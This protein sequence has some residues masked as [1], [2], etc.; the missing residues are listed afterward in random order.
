MD[1]SRNMILAIV[2]SALVLIGWSFVSEQVAPTPP[3]PAPETAEEADVVLPASETA[4]VEETAVTQTVDEALG[5]ATAARIAIETPRLQGSINL[6]G[7]RIDDLVLLDHFETNEPD[8]APIRLLAPEGTEA[9]YFAHFGWAGDGV[10]MPDGDTI[11]QADSETLAPDSPVTMRW[12]NGTGQLFEIEL[13][14][15]ED[16]LFTVGQRVSNTSDAPISA[17][18]YA[19]LMHR[20]EMQSAGAPDP[21]TWLI[22]T[23]PYGFWDD[24]LH[25]DLDFSDL[26]EAGSAGERFALQNGWLGFNGKYWLGALAPAGDRQV[27]AA[28]MALT[29]GR[30]QAVFTGQ[31]TVI[32]AGRAMTADTHFFAG[33][34]ETH[35]LERYEVEAGIN[36]LDRAIDWGWFY[37]FELPLFYLLSWLFTTVGNFGVAIILMTFIVRGLMFPIAQKQ[38]SS[39]AGM[40]AVQPKMKELQERYKDD[41]PKMQQEVLALYQREKVNPLAGCLPIFLQIPIFYALYKVLLVSVEMRHEPFALWLQ[42]L[43]AP[44]PLT[45]VNLFGLL[46]FDPPSWLAIGILPI[47]LGI[48]MYLQFKLNPAQMDPT[49]QKI[50]EFMPWIFM[51]IMAPFAAGL[52]LYWVT[53][54]L[55]T[56]AQ[57]K[58]LYS[59]D[60][61]LKEQAKMAKE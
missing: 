51:F 49:Q 16:F 27:D 52:Q 28:F 43:S 36:Q 45:P 55:L 17:R 53:S 34:K 61:R 8:S 20:G 15:D 60:P 46:A 50:F 40:R 24:V 59:R 48:T 5:T 58:W 3:P 13:Q 2:L 11:W 23:G 38:F 35:L 42:D 47:L 1:S 7:A 10:E 6:R 37:W 4:P 18:P 29:D 26:D 21:D 39:M 33:A 41:K 14:V 32:E 44:D 25:R 19:L 22:H 31:P 54:N 56:I 9:S 57:Q 12:R 30:Y